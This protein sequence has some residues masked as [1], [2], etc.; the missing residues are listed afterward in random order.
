[1]I[2]LWKRFDKKTR[3]AAQTYRMAWSALCI[4]DPNSSWTS[5]LKELKDKDISGPG[6]DLEDN[7]T[8]KSHY[9]P[10]WIW[11][12]AHS[13]NSNLELDEEEFNANMWIEWVKARA[14]M[15]WWKEEFLI[16]QEEMCHVIVYHKWK[17]AWWQE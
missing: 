15:M 3:Q 10:S 2:T 6:K 14:H 16:I 7:S 17:A 5:R 12:V 13:S 4:L 8:T 11:L 9:E 1:M